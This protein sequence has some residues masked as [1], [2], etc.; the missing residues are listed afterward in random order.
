MLRTPI[1]LVELAGESLES[2]A[3]RVAGYVHQHRDHVQAIIQML[4][5]ALAQMSGPSPAMARLKGTTERVA[6]ASGLG[7]LVKLRG[8]IEAGLAALHQYHAEQACVEE[9][10]PQ[11]A[12]D[13]EV[14]TGSYVA[15]FRLQRAELIAGRFG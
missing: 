10:K 9:P 5:D 12:D 8:E 14:L 11:A 3:H 13:I 4:T 2:Y 15:A 1:G 6:T 7:D